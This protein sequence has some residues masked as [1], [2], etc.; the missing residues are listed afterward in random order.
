MS[1]PVPAIVDIVSFKGRL[2]VRNKKCS[3]TLVK[4]I[5]ILT[6]RCFKVPNIFVES[7]D[8][9]CPIVSSLDDESCIIEG[10]EPL[11]GGFCCNAHSS[12]LAVNIF[13]YV[14]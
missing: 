2:T 12:C 4:S 13:H 10:P 9:D 6:A 8:T 1:C 7:L 3:M 11:G 5:D 14:D